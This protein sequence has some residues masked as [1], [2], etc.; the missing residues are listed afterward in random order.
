MQLSIGGGGGGV[1]KYIN[2]PGAPPDLN[3]DLFSMQRVRGLGTGADDLYLYTF[4]RRRL[5]EDTQGG[6][7]LH[8]RRNRKNVQ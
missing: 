2:L 1:G 7:N 4:V 3:M 5:V 6:M 8:K